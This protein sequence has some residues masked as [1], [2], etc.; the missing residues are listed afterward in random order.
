M[1]DRKAVIK[2]ADMAEDMQ[3]DA[4][5]CATQALEKY[6][7]EKDIAAFIKKEFD[8]KYNP[9]WHAIVGR[10]FGSYVTHETKHFIYFYLGQVACS[11]LCLSTWLATARG[12]PRYSIGGEGSNKSLV[13]AALWAYDRAEKAG[14]QVPT[15]CPRCGRPGEPLTWIRLTFWM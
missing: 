11:R 15:V 13:C 3:Q 6:N 14:C 8:K 4:I 7:I 12:R 5:D 9:T 1:A 10:N 2:N